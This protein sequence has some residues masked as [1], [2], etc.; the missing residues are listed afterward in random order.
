MENKNGWLYL[1]LYIVSLR[2]YLESGFSWGTDAPA[3]EIKLL[4]KF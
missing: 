1:K 2:I 4:Y 3:E